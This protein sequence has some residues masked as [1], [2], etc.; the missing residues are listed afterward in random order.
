MESLFPS[1]AVFLARAKLFSEKRQPREN[2][3]E[4]WALAIIVSLGSKLATLILF[5]APISFSG[6]IV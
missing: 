1:K 2:G 3:E 5:I 6:R 4:V